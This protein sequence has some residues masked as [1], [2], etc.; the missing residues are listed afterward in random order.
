[1]G[2]A[3]DEKD[4]GLLNQPDEEN[5][6]AEP[7]EDRGKRN[8]DQVAKMFSGRGEEKHLKQISHLLPI[9]IQC[10]SLVSFCKFGSMA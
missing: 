10:V 9:T 3:D 6:E 4:E 7:G 2:W 5:K 8:Q 1:M